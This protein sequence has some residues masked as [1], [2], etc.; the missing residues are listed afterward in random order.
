MSDD[1][2]GLKS[3]A[4]ITKSGVRKIFTPHTPVNEINHLFGR[5]GDVR[6]MVS[7]IRNPGQHILIYGDR[8]VGKTSLAKSTCSLILERISNSCLITKSCDSGDTFSSLFIEPL[9][10]VGLDSS[11]ERQ[12]KSIKQSG[13]AGLSIPV[14]NAGIQSDRQTD[15]VHSNSLKLD[16]PSWV[17]QQLKDFNCIYLIDE[18]DTL[19]NENDKHKLSELIKALSD[20]NS[21][22]K[23]IIVGIAKT[24]SELTA[25]HKSIQRCLKEIHLDRMSDEDI[26]KIILNG[27]NNIKPKRIPKD[28]VVESIVDI[29]SGFPHYAHLIC[30]SC[31]EL[32]ITKD[33]SHIEI[34]ILDEAL[35]EVAMDLESTFS[36]N[37][38]NVLRSTNNPQEYKLIL[39]AAAHCQKRDFRNTE[40]ADK[41]FQLYGTSINSSTLNSRLAK[42]AKTNNDNNILSR[43]AKACYSF[44]DPR[45]PSFVKIKFNHLLDANVDQTA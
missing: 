4:K 25:G 16:S 13:K 17:A 10:K 27:M 32:A 26:R 12:T 11:I 21:N 18:V 8:G 2:F 44:K 3:E 15:T 5:E 43:T 36:E 19:S 20:F 39:L 33:L 29:S 31:A 41:I 6:R 30:L 42:L 38:N 14:L 7:L 34:A 40:L 35:V 28:E 23:I 24:A 37:L 45:M 9:M 1:L 22:F